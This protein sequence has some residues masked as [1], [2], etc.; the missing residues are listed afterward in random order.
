LKKS[1]TFKIALGVFGLVGFIQLIA[2]G[3]AFARRA[4][5]EKEVIKVKEA[6]VLILKDVITPEPEPQPE[7]IAP[8]HTI[9]ADEIAKRFVPNGYVK[10]EE[11]EDV[12][13]VLYAGEVKLPPSP[14]GFGYVIKHP[15]VEKLLGRARDSYILGDMMAAVTYLDQAKVEDPGEAAVVDME[16]QIAEGMGAYDK[17]TNLYMTVFQMGVEA[18]PYYQRA[19]VKIEK[20]VGD[21][22]EDGAFMLLGTVNILRDK[23]GRRSKVV[24]PIRAR[25]GEFIVGN[26]VEISVQFYDLVNGDKIE[27]AANNADIASV[28]QNK[29]VSWTERNE[30]TLEVSY[31]IPEVDDRMEEIFGKRKY[32]GQV[33]ELYYKGKI[34]DVIAHPRS[35]HHVH[36]QKNA[37][38][39]NGGDDFSKQLE[40]L[41]DMNLSNPLLPEKPR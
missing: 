24:V 41:D 37:S 18:G 31:A 39:Y 22:L 32:Y 27:P 30:E 7:I 28:F 21:R 12:D 34:Q 38:K 11:P 33:I 25:E 5:I 9:S 4:G 35:L 29:N 16:A 15:K 17:A 6:P 14:T 1:P 36:A 2:V 20:G 10:P 8:P 3:S 26:Q 40:L 23:S 13:S 19:A